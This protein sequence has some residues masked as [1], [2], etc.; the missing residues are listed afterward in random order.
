MSAKKFTEVD[1]RKQ[2]KKFRPHLRH[3]TQYKLQLCVLCTRVVVANIFFIAVFFFLCLWK[4]T[5]FIFE[6]EMR[7]QKGLCSF[8]CT[9][10]KKRKTFTR[11]P[12]Y[13]G[14][15]RRNS[16]ADI[17]YKALQASL[18]TIFIYKSREMIKNCFR[19]S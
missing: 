9:R 8:V 5:L 7:I 19:V 2:S 12:K 3:K 10:K 4:N 6:F 1:A 17:D 13:D 14:G 11:H 15:R 18:H 16:N